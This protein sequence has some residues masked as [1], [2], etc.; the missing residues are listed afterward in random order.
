MNTYTFYANGLVFSLV[1][2]D[3][4]NDIYRVPKSHDILM[5]IRPVE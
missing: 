4:Y 5:F 3:L 1:L 2:S